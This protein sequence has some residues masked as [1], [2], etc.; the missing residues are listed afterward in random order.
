M[1]FKC[2]FYFFNSIVKYSFF[3]KAETMH[4]T[5]KGLTI[6]LNDLGTGSAKAV[7]TVVASNV[8]TNEY[9]NENTENWIEYVLYVSNTVSEDA[10][11]FTLTFDFGTTAKYIEN[12]DLD[13]T[14]GYAIVT[15]PVGYVISEEDFEKV[16]ENLKNT[17]LIL[18]MLIT[19][20]KIIKSTAI[21]QTAKNNLSLSCATPA[22]AY[23]SAS[24]LEILNDF[25]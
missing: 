14:R 8:T 21:T 16:F 22:K 12:G 7:D 9:E 15:A 19:I 20:T 5:E 13:L 25:I 18:A 3:V 11:Q 10:R 1:I 24:I 6:T 4:P 17:F 2:E 23:E